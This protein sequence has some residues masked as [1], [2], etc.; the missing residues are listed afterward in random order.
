MRTA[1]QT[2]SSRYQ[3]T[4]DSRGARRGKKIIG[5]GGG[6]Y[7]LVE[8]LVLLVGIVGE[9]VVQVVL[10]DCVH[11]VVGHI[12]TLFPF[13]K[14]LTLPMK[15]GFWGFGVLRLQVFTFARGIMA[16]E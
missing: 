3:R 5:R 10:G 1:S 6:T 14:L 13:L 9:V 8:L 15:T 11:Y 7:D 16:P 2:V 4:R 12:Q